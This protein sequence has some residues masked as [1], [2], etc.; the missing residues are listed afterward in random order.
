MHKSATAELKSKNV[1][2]KKKTSVTISFG[3]GVVPTL[4][5]SAGSKEAS[6]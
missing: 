6:H 1:L 4:T 5:Y 3:I 2:T